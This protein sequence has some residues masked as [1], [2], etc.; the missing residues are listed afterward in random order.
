MS[1]DHIYRV[2]QVEVK[3]TLGQNTIEVQVPSK[4]YGYESSPYT[5]QF[6]VPRERYS[7]DKLTGA[8]VRAY[9]LGIEAHR[10]EVS[11]ILMKLTHPN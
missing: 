10:R 5:F 11:E 8:L 3:A 2:M 6:D 7:Y 4:M 9:E 1:K